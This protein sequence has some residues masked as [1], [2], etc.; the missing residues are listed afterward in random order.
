[1]SVSNPK[2][3]QVQLY[4]NLLH[5][6]VRKGALNDAVFR[7]FVNAFKK[8]F[9]EAKWDRVRKFWELPLQENGRLVWFVNLFFGGDAI[10]YL[11]D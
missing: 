7:R 6:R 10:E 8:E 5:I 4:H 9:P 11:K 3:I 2:P 1:M